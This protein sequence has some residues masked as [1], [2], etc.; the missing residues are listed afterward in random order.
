MPFDRAA[1]MRT[2]RVKQRQQFDAE[3]RCTRCGGERADDGHAI[4]PECRE[5]ANTHGIAARA[6]NIAAGLCSSCGKEPVA[7][8]L[9]AGKPKKMCTKCTTKVKT[10]R[11]KRLNEG[12]PREPCLACPA[13][14][15]RPR[16][17]KAA[18]PAAAYVDPDRELAVQAFRAAARGLIQIANERQDDVALRRTTQALVNSARVILEA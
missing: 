7:P 6:R 10:R 1:Y 17:P 4:C 14:G 15:K 8:G 12:P 3:G 11:R 18:A 2:W 13:Y 9:R 5:R 16:K